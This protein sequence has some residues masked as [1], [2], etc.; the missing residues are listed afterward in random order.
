MK[1][2]ILQALDK[3]LYEL[4]PVKKTKIVEKSYY[5]NSGSIQ[6]IERQVKEIS[7]KTSIDT[8][9]MYIY[10]KEDAE[11]A[12]IVPTIHELTLQEIEQ[13]VARSFNLRCFKHVYNNLISNGFTRISSPQSKYKT[14]DDTTVYTM[15]L[16][17][18]YDRLVDYFL[19]S[20][21]F[22]DILLNERAKK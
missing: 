7:L 13:R 16:T 5:L 15:F 20:F 17:K 2:L 1:N 3:C 21:K 10:S 8:H 6:E 12:V 9:H 18:Q 14:F 22:K 11:M 4:P 19:L